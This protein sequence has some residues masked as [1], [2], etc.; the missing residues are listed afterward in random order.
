MIKQRAEFILL[1]YFSLLLFVVIGL[2]TETFYKFLLNLTIYP[3]NF[4]LNLFYNSIVSANFIYLESIIIEIIPACV[5]VSAYILLLILNLTTPMS[6]RTRIRSL[7]FSFLALLAVNI[8]RIVLL[9]VLLLQNSTYFNAVHLI[10]WYFLSIIL[11]VA[12]WFLTA[13]VFKI[14][15]IPI[16]ADF[17]AVIKNITIKSDNK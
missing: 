1:R 16:Y 11:V 9:S 14:K 7:I 10:F 2:F 8:I 13:Y 5:A 15:N 3:T 4:I 6:P 12:I 17:K